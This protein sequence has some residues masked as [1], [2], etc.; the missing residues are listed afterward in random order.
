MK[1]CVKILLAL[2]LSM[3]ILIAPVSVY[4]DDEGTSETLG[5]ISDNS[6]EGNQGED[7]GGNN[8]AYDGGEYGA[9]D[10]DGLE[11]MSEQ[12]VGESSN[13]NEPAIP[14]ETPR[15]TKNT[16]TPIKQTTPAKTTTRK[17]MEATQATSATPV[18]EEVEK[19]EEATTENGIVE[20]EVISVA[21]EVKVDETAE[22]NVE[23]SQNIDGNAVQ[24]MAH[25][26]T[27]ALVVGAAGVALTYGFIKRPSK[28]VV[29]DTDEPVEKNAKPEAEK[30]IV[31]V[32]PTK[33]TTKLAATKPA[34][35]KPVAT[36]KKSTTKAIAKS[37]AKTVAKTVAKK[38]TVKAA[39]GP[40][41]K[42]TKK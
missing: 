17:T 41:S 28:V 16:A 8:S 34:A 21:E 4:A 12:T 1:K 29:K 31:R 39:T 13:I 24:T 19:A 11:Y 14:Q 18:T 37:T 42:T 27:A 35:T 6:D 25:L 33:T 32:M 36:T 30:Q 10:D 15:E 26:A 23:E 2:V 5:D 22:E 20:A 7:V 3:V 38:N 40:K 9:N